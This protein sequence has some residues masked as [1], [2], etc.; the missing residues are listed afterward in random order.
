L[1]HYGSRLKN[2]DQAMSSDSN[3]DPARPPARP[4][5]ALCAGAPTRM[6]WAALALALLWVTISW[7]LS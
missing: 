5:S 6:L 4:N 2:H 3:N 7:A 1:L